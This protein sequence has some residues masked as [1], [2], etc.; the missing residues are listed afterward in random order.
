MGSAD[1]PLFDLTLFWWLPFF[2]LADFRFRPDAM[3]FGPAPL[4]AWADPERAGAVTESNELDSTAG[5][6][7]KC[8]AQECDEKATEHHSLPWQE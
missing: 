6:T 8:S 1:L 4:K 7:R 3:V 2:D 5:A